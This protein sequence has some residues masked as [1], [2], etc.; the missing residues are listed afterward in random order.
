MLLFLILLLTEV[1]TFVVLRQHLLKDSKTL[2]NITILLNSLLSIWLWIIYI[3]YSSHR[4]FYDSPDHV[5][6]QMALSGMI[7]SVVLPRMIVIVFHFIG[8][9][10]NLIRLRK[11]VHLKWLTNTGFVFGTII[12]VITLGGVLIGKHNFKYNNVS[13]AMSN[14]HPDLENF[15]IVH[16]SDLHLAS[17]Y[18]SSEKLES[19]MQKITGLNPDLIVNSGDFIT[20]GWREFGRNDTI[21]SI[22]RARYGKIAVM[23]NHDEGIYNPDFTEADLT[24]NKLIINN[25]VSQSGYL[26]L[27]NESA[28]LIVGN[29][30]ISI[31]GVRTGGRY[32]HII[33]A[34]LDTVLKG[35]DS[36]DFHILITHDPNQWINEVAGKRKDVE[37]T[38]SGH[39][40]GMQMG[41]MTKRFK[42]SPAQYIYPNWDGLYENDNQFQYVNRGL[43]VLA[44][45]FRIWMPPEITVITLKGE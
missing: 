36:A 45:P 17:F 29:S 44:I 40:H 39:T 42:W 19:V 41:I 14:L 9:L 15:R 3:K 37:L 30:K 23:G 16:I 21:L 1:L 4:S 6:L 31:T 12:L 24:N 18:H 38:L 43:G 2:Y 28:S 35:A 7:C 11:N 5:W 34:N 8:R 10:I 32:P 13:L 22:A 33:H 25:L 20:F 27:Q 26:M